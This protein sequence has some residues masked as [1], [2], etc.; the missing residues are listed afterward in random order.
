MRRPHH[1][2]RYSDNHKFKMSLL[3]HVVKA[4]LITG[5]NRLNVALLRRNW[6]VQPAMKKWDSSYEPSN[7]MRK[8]S[9]PKNVIE[10]MTVTR[11]AEPCGIQGSESCQIWVSWKQL[12][13]CS[14]PKLESVQDA[15]SGVE[16]HP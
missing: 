5:R 13:T 11:H 9:V 12:W 6:Q 2:R 1:F 3:Q 7:G 16:K 15:G 10:L 4:A 14:G 8:V